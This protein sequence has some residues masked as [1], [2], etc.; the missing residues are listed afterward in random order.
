MRQAATPPSS[1]P[2]REQPSPD[3]PRQPPRA[4]PKG[5]AGPRG[6]TATARPAS[7]CQTTASLSAPPAP[8]PAKHPQA[9]P[10]APQQTSS[11][12]NSTPATTPRANQHRSH[13]S[14]QP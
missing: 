11:N 7:A 13:P 12:Q 2:H 10:Q 9:C 5:N 14:P 4:P 8:S 3:E 1:T 6:H